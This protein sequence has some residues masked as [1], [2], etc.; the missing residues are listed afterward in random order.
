MERPK[1]AR[2]EMNQ[3]LQTR[4]PRHPL[5]SECII[6]DIN[7]MA[8]STSI[9]IIDI[10]N[11][12]SSISTTW[13][14]SVAHTHLTHIT[15]THLTTHITHT[16]TH[17][18]ISLIIIQLTSHGAGGGN[19]KIRNHH[20]IIA[21]VMSLENLPGIGEPGIQRSHVAKDMLVLLPDTATY[22]LRGG[23]L[24]RHR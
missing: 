18:T 1:F 20:R 12:L 2:T 9:F 11:T 22:H 6:I 14:L 21:R 24:P 15:H 3:H 17:I 13:G 19:P 16:H 8:T 4:T 5:Y 10:Y 7:D 23:Q